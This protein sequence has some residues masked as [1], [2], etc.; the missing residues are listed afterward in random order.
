MLKEITGAQSH[1]NVE[2]TLNLICLHSE[3]GEV[4]RSTDIAGPQ[5]AWA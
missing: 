5:V 2:L 1:H 3:Q 4:V